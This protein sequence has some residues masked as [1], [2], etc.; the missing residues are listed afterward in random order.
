MKTKYESQDHVLFDHKEDCE[1]RDAIIALSNRVARARYSK[2]M[3]E[4]NLSH[5]IRGLLFNYQDEIL[6]LLTERE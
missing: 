5:A 4:E 1:R 2:A 3:T 6:E